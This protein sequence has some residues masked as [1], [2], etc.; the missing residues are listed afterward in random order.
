MF[1]LRIL[2][3]VRATYREVHITGGRVWRIVANKVV[4]PM[5]QLADEAVVAEPFELVQFE[6][7]RAVHVVWRQRAA[8]RVVEQHHAR[9]ILLAV[10]C[11]GP[12]EKLGGLG[13]A[14]V[15][16]DAHYGVAFV[17]QGPE[18]GNVVAHQHVA[19]HE[20]RPTVVAAQAGRE[21]ARE[22]EVGGLQRR[23]LAP[24]H[25]LQVAERQRSDAHRLRRPGQDAV[26]QHMPRNC[27]P[28]VEADEHADHDGGNFASGRAGNSLNNWRKYGV[29]YML[30][31]MAASSTPQLMRNSSGHGNQ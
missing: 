2:G 25:A 18:L 7:G 19:I 31:A 11:L 4:P 28:G 12:V 9:P 22:R 30:R 8:S 13:R 27:F 6:P 29:V 10:R 5:R 20:Q 24:E 1:A 17:S 16:L 3:E 26:R 23:G 21:E 14:V 15:V